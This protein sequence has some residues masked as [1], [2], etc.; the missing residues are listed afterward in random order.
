M[1]EDRGKVRKS[2]RWESRKVCMLVQRKSQK[3]ASITGMCRGDRIPSTTPPYT[4]DHIHTVQYY[5]LVT[6]HSEYYLPHI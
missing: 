3:I 6:S 5:S 2:K 4:S 1:R